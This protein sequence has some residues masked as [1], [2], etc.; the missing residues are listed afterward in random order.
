MSLIDELTRR[1]VV[2]VAAACL[3][4]GWAIIEISRTVVPALQLPVWTTTLLV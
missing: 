3:A 1:N 4:L 2:R